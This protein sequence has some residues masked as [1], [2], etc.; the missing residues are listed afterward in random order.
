[1][2]QHVLVVVH[3]GSAC[4]SA[5]FNLGKYEARSARDELV[6]EIKNWTGGVI[7]I[8]GDFSDELPDYPALNEA[9]LGV[10]FR[11]K[12][13][14]QV[15]D[16]R[17]GQDPAQVRVIG[18][19]IDGLELDLLATT[20]HVTGAWHIADH[21]TMTGCVGSVQEELLRMGGKACVSEM[22]VPWPVYSGARFAPSLNAALCP[23]RFIV[24]IFGRD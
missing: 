8:D 7:V 9:I 21:P 4:G 23:G 6:S 22:A 17:Q 16:R 18:E 19:V 14:G 15:S 12:L 20:F 1:M 3:P 2:S 13:S 24:S 11:A 10:L 5:D